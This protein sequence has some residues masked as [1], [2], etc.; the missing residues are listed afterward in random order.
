MIPALLA[1]VAVKPVMLMCFQ[2][3]VVL[4]TVPLGAVTGSLGALGY[5]LWMLMGVATSLMVR[6]EYV[7][8]CTVPPRPSLAFRRMPFEVPLNLQFSTQ[9]WSTPSLV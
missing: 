2:M 1:P 5:Q 6:P 3:G 4:S 9:R 7:R 8:Y